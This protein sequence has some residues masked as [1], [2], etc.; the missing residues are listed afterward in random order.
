MLFSVHPP[1]SHIMRTHSVAIRIGIVLQQCLLRIFRASTLRR[2]T[3]STQRSASVILAISIVE[4]AAYDDDDN[5][6]VGDND[7]DDDALDG[8]IVLAKCRMKRSLPGLR[9]HLCM[10]LWSGE[11]RLQAG[12]ATRCWITSSSIHH[13]CCMPRKDDS[14][15]EKRCTRTMLAYG[16]IS[17]ASTMCLFSQ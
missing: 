13:P 5:D 8:C 11:C 1:T 16:C 4:D 6:D 2:Q 10:R 9:D 15:E 17:P 7:D 12:A 14:N 3:F